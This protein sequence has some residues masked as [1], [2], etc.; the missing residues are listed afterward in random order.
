M[1]AFAALGEAAHEP[2][3]ERSFFDDDGSGLF[4]FLESGEHIGDG[5]VAA[6]RGDPFAG[7]RDGG[8]FGELAV[9]VERDD[10]LVG[11]DSWLRWIRMHEGLLV[12]VV[13]Y[14]VRLN[15]PQGAPLHTSSCRRLCVGMLPGIVG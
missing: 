1:H 6:L 11:F 5:G 15:A 4:D 13:P 7:G 12:R 10:S 14:G 2:V 3:G 8:E 9:N